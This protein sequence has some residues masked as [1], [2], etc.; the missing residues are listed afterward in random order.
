M[1]RVQSER[2]RRNNVVT[3]FV[4]YQG[5]LLLLRRSK[6]VKTMKGK[7]AA[8][9]GYI[10]MSTDPL[11]QAM[12]EVEEE[13]GLSNENVRVLRVGQPLEV[14]DP[15]NQNTTWIVHPYFFRTNTN[16][17]KLDWEHDKYLWINP[18]EIKDYDTVPK[19]RET[20]DNVFPVG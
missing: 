17:V 2:K 16:V 11:R 5:K 9:S 15:Y 7:W 14:V 8:I 1:S 18:Q 13:T 19:L 6:K 3:A 12:K 10:E 20:L 4:Q